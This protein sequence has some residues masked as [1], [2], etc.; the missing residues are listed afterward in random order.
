MT[1][2]TDIENAIKTMEL[3][4][5]RGVTGIIVRADNDPEVLSYII[6]IEETIRGFKNELQ[7]L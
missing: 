2:K 5:R 3:M 6:T 7:Y 1:D 4:S